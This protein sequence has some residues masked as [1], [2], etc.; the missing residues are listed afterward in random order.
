MYISTIQL[1]REMGVD[2]RIGKFFVDRKVPDN[3]SFWKGRLL[4][5]SFGNGY[6]SIPVY[7][8]ILYRL[9]LP[10]E[11]LLDEKHIL[12]MES[13]MHFA[14]LHERNEITFVEELSRIRKLLVGRIRD[15]DYYSALNLYL[16][17]TILKPL[18]PFGL[19]FPSLNRADVFLYILCDLPLS[20][21]QWQKAIRYWYA[22]HPNY[23]VM[24]DIRDFVKDRDNGDENVIIDLGKGLEG[25]EK[26]FMIYR[27]NCATL[28]EINPL[29]AKFLSAY[30]VRLR[31]LIPA[32]S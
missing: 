7:Y 23:L 17:Q 22:L 25:F 27:K 19:P 1:E 30:E 5:V 8:D 28:E 15:S 21:Q 16:D 11:V 10:V 3:N 2:K 4:Y 31:E 9:G 29:L 6:L 26:T 14:I 18:G 13:L 12:F 32:N 20:K 24:D